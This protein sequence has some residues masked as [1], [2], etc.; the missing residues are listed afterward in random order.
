MKKGLL[1][2]L[3][4]ASFSA[5]CFAQMATFGLKSGMNISNIYDTEGDGPDSRF[6][7]IGGAFCDFDFVSFG[8]QP[9]VLFSQKGW[10]YDIG[11]RYNYFEIPVLI[12]IPLT[13]KFRVSPYLGP[14]ANFL[15]NAKVFDLDMSQYVVSPD[16][17]LVLGAEIKTKH[18]VS[19][20]IRYTRG[21]RKIIKDEPYESY[22]I[23]H[24]V[25][26]IMLGLH[27]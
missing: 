25:F 20:D 6:G 26:S 12:K 4:L 1:V 3:I 11:C 9:E 15:L 27:P 14:A 2:I 17:G 7:F 10:K 16:I 18:K 19:L 23:K 21:L 22:D 13:K 24:S 5:L 8:I